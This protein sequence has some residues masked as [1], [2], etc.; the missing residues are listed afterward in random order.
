MGR[1][2]YDSRRMRRAA[3]RAARRRLLDRPAALAAL[4]CA[5]ALLAAAGVRAEINSVAFPSPAW[6]PPETSYV[7]AAQAVLSFDMDADPGRYRVDVYPSGSDHVLVSDDFEHE[8]AAGATERHYVAV[9]LQ[10]GDNVFRL[11]LTELLDAGGGATYATGP[12]PTI[13]RDLETSIVYLSLDAVEPYERITTSSDAVLHYTIGGTA[14]LYQ[15]DVVNLGSVVHTQIVSAGSGTVGP[16]PL[17]TGENNL[18]LRAQAM[19]FFSDSTELESN[20]HAV[21][22]DPDPPQI[23]GLQIAFPT[24]P[25]EDAVVNI[26]GFTEP[27]SLVTV[28]DDRGSVYTK[29]ANDLGF[30]SFL[31]VDLPL[32]P[33]GPTTTVYTVTAEDQA[34]NVSLPATVSGTRILGEPKFH[35]IALDPF[36]G[37]FLSPGRTVMIRGSASQYSAPY[38]VNFFLRA[39]TGMPLIEESIAD[40]NAFTPFEKDIAL[41]P[42]DTQPDQ[43]V[44]FSVEAEVVSSAGVSARHFLGEITLDVADPMAVIFNDTRFDGVFHTRS[45]MVTFEGAAERWSTVVFSDLSGAVYRPGRSIRTDATNIAAGGEFRTALDLSSLPE[46][47]YVLD[48]AVVAA[49]GRSGPAS[50]KRLTLVRD[51][52]A[53]RVQAVLIDGRPVPAPGGLFLPASKLVAVRITMNE[54]MALPPRVFVTERG[55][56]ALEAPLGA[57]I[58]K[59]RVYEYN[60]A[61]RPG[62]EYDGPA[63]LTVVGGADLA[64]NPVAPAWSVAD[65]FVKDTRAP[66]VDPELTV[67]A[68]GSTVCSAPEPLRIVLKEPDD[69]IEPASGVDISA[70]YVEAFG[71]FETS[72]ARKLEGTLVRFSPSTLE[73]TFAPGAMEEDGTYRVEVHCVDRAGNERVE[74]L[75]YRLDSTALPPSVVTTFVPAGPCLDA[76]AWPTGADGRMYVSVFVEDGAT[77]AVDLSGSVLSLERNRPL[78]RP[79]SGATQVTTPGELRFVLD[80]SLPSDGSADGVYTATA[81]I[82]DSAGNLGRTVTHTFHYDNT[83]PFVVD[84]WSQVPYEPITTAPLFFPADGAVVRGPLRY[85]HAVVCDGVAADGD[86]GCGLSLDPSTG[87]SVVLTLVEAHESTSIP[88]GTSTTS[89]V[90]TTLRFVSVDGAEDSP[91]RLAYAQL[92]LFVDPVTG[93]PAG[94]PASGTWDGE[95]ELTVVPVDRA[96]NRGGPRSVR[97]CYDTVPPGIEVGGITNGEVVSAGV[98]QTT[99]TAWDDDKTDH[100]DGLGVRAVQVRIEALDEGG[101]AVLPP[102]VDWTD[103]ELP[104]NLH[105]LPAETSVPWSVAM[106]V[107]WDYEGPARIIFRAVDAAGNETRVSRD[108]TILASPMRPPRLLEPEEGAHLPGAVVRFAWTRVDGASGYRLTITGSD[109]SSRTFET[110]LENDELSISLVGW[111]EDRYTWTVQALDT[112]GIG[113]APALRRSFVLDRT[114][115]TVVR[116]DVYEATPHDETGGDALGRQFRVAVEFSE[117]MDYTS[118]PVVTL[119]PPASSA[120]ALVVTTISHDGSSW[121]GLLTLPEDG[122]PVYDGVMRLR[123]SRAADLAGNPMAEDAVSNVEIDT[124]PWFDV[125]AFSNPVDTREIIFHFKARRYP[126]GPLV[127][128]PVVPLVKISQPSRDE[129]V[130]EMHRLDGS[131]FYGMYRL[132]KTVAGPAVIRIFSTDVEGNRGTRTISFDIASLAGAGSWSAPLLGGAASLTVLGGSSGAAPGRVAFIAGRYLEATP[133]GCDP[134]GFDLVLPLAALVAQGGDLSGWVR[135]DEEWLLSRTP[136]PAGKDSSGDASRIPRGWGVYV[137]SSEGFRPLP[138]VREQGELCARIEGSGTCYLALDRK[139]PALASAADVSGSG[140]AAVALVR[141]TELGS[142]VDPDSIVACVDG[143]P[144]PAVWDERR[145]QVRVELPRAATRGVA[146]LELQVRDE[147]G[148]LARAVLPLKGPGRPDVLAFVPYPNPA[149]GGRVWF[150]LSLDEAAEKWR[151][152]I[153]DASGRRVYRTGGGALPAGESRLSWACVASS[154]R[155]VAAGVYFARITVYG[156]GGRSS[157][158]AKVAVLP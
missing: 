134:C 137:A 81:R 36:D 44:V 19:D 93:E 154:G 123:V 6:S 155:K 43:D 84:G 7:Q 102:L 57:E 62:G 35:Y 97:F 111:K 96:G 31:G 148:N 10:E 158:T 109:G 122:E 52:T 130:L 39:G 88:V 47:I 5:W 28:E 156:G 147:A 90:I 26:Q 95:W 30:F 18:W 126:G 53:P 9:P 71:P 32:D 75:I 29:R 40:L 17:S 151:L 139:P 119:E 50:R 136:A 67:P 76:D 2:M 114:P 66:V 48:C 78:P 56:D 69:S 138:L 42:D 110:G 74:T 55:G 61:T 153:H 15:L 103:A 128:L 145:S 129:Q 64:G 73:Y 41:P 112:Q 11:R 152:S 24:M 25:T 68:D 49:S 16:I 132:D 21:V 23:S 117:P 91:L 65:A 37:A 150:R 140:D 107:P 85:V 127:V 98:L 14:S 27:Y 133:R 13:R 1:K 63:V 83:P 45:P 8:T 92:D 115:P 58:V 99:G 33:P 72:P 22:Y 89:A 106:T 82:R 12:S 86:R 142:G 157:A 80:S 87:T 59:G 60:Y 149:R 125:A 70:C 54:Q 100:D 34:G 4:L 101:G 131:I 118:G 108:V 121:R 20:Y 79:V 120:P 51:T 143:R 3:L 94:L 113:G 144:V 135:I 146:S 38:R 124:G 116:V 77:Q 141:V 105:T 46:G 104:Q